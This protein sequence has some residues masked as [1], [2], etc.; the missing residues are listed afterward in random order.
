MALSTADPVGYRS[1]IDSAARYLMG[2]QNPNGSWDYSQRLA[3]DTS[4]SQYAVL[5]LWE[6]ENAGVNVGP[7]VWDRAASWYLSSQS[8]EGSW[9]YHRDEGG[10]E[11]LS[12]TAAGVGSLLICSR[13]LAPYRAPTQTINPLFIPLVSDA[14]KKRYNPE[15]SPQ[16]LTQGIRNG[17]GWLGANFTTSNNAIIGHS[18]Y[19]APLRDRANR[20][21]GRSGHAR[22]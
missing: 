17:L 11:T 3:G 20:G 1:E 5:G 21:P 4:I 19:Y 16:R 2:R 15:T 18:P 8:G 9:N 22:A 6:A 10:P 12:M 14:E 13:Q 7:S